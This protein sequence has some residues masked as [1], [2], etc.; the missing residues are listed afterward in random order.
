[1]DSRPPGDFVNGEG[2][3]V[4]QHAGVYHYTI[5]QRKGL[6]LATGERTYVNRI[7]PETNTVQVGTREEAMSTRCIV[8]RVNW[9]VPESELPS[10]G[11]S[12]QIRYNHDAQAVKLVPL[13][14]ERV[15]L[16]FSDPQHAITPGQ[17]AV[18]YH[19]DYV[20]GG[21]TIASVLS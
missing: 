2:D 21:G 6:G 4:G 11:L 9:F 16:E 14:N 13:D 20:L 10:Q 19:G 3:V 18:F 12:A 8:D 5:G 1:M 7:D 15:R 17:S